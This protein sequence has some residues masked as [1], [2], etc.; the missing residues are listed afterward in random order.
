MSILVLDPAVDARGSI[1]G[2]VCEGCCAKGCW[3]LGGGGSFLVVQ[4]KV[5]GEPVETE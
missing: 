4:T 1:C 2:V 3:Y 5:Q